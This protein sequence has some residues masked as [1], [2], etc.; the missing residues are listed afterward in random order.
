[1]SWIHFFSLLGG[2][3]D[4]ATE[5]TVT[6]VNEDR[7]GDGFIESEDCNDDDASIFPESEE[8]CDGIDNNCD[9]N[10][11]EDVT[12]TFYAD[13]DGDGFGNANIMV[14]A[15]SEPSGFVSNGSDCDDTESNSY[16]GGTEIC[17]GKDNDCNGD[18]DDGIDAELYVDVDGDGFGDDSIPMVGCALDTGLSTLGGDCDDNNIYIH[19]L[20]DES[21]DG[22]DN[23]CDGNV[24]EDVLLTFY[25]DE[26]EDGYGDDATSTTACEQPADYSAQSGDCAL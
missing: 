23:N 16:P 26:D 10:I 21:C 24:D 12:T 8:I 7:D 14:E 1:M 18:I 25:L 11:D 19:P 3:E 17:D 20:I 9:G 4:T 22:I 2:C 13:S 6:E 5:K 15:C